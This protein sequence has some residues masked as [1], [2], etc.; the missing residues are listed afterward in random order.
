M[1]LFPSEKVTC[2]FSHVKFPMWLFTC[3]ISHVKSHMWN[4]T[5]ETSHAK[6]HMWYFTCE[7][8]HVK[9]HRWNH[10][11]NLSHGKVFLCDFSNQTVNV[12]ESGRARQTVVGTMYERSC[13]YE[14]CYGV[15]LKTFLSQIG[16]TRL[17]DYKAMQSKDCL[18]IVSIHKTWANNFAMRFICPGTA[19]FKLTTHK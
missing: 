8:S 17:S 10:M 11:W 16:R 7:I 6:F 19:L 14:I 5:R 2:E 3:E 18:C 13:T 1:W 15:T 12:V 4:F 9:F